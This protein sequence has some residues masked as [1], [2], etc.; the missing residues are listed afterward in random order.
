MDKDVIELYASANGDRWFLHRGADGVPVVRHVPNV[1]SGGKPSDAS[2]ADFLASA[3]A[4]PQGEAL[5]ASIADLAGCAV[6]RQFSAVRVT[7]NQPVA[8]GL[9][10]AA[11]RVRTF[12]NER[13][14]TNASGF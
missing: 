7:A 6:G 4:T 12:A 10:L 11:A 5:T 9:L 2:V 1:A 8:D 14:L 13:H 3:Y